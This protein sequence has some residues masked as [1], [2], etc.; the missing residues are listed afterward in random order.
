ME[1][2]IEYFSNTCP[3]DYLVINPDGLRLCLS[4]DEETVEINNHISNSFLQVVMDEFNFKPVPHSNI[5]ILQL[6]K[7]MK[8]EKHI[9]L[10]TV[11]QVQ[12]QEEQGFLLT[13]EVLNVILS[14]EDISLQAKALLTCFCVKPKWTLKEL[15][16]KG[17]H[18]HDNVKDV[19]T[20]LKQLCIL[21]NDDTHVYVVK[22][23]ID[24]LIACSIENI[25]PYPFIIKR[26]N[27]SY[28]NTHLLKI[29]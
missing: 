28:R 5:S 10:P 8:S 1:H 20:E 15:Y 18:Y 13:P 27:L 6:H 9:N 12:K 26:A 2:I 19:L 17:V 7:W 11:I 4:K 29:N 16:H 21:Q 3:V 23:Y 14:L 24:Y 25:V 22:E